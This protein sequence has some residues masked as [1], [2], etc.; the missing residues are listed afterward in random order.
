MT[1][2]QQHC[3]PLG[4]WVHYF[5]NP[6][7]AG[8]D[9]LYSVAVLLLHWTVWICRLSRAKAVWSSMLKVDHFHFQMIQL[10]D[11]FPCRSIWSRWVIPK[12]KNCVLVVMCSSTAWEHICLLFFGTPVNNFYFDSYICSLFHARVCVFTTQSAYRKVA[13]MISQ[14]VSPS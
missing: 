4:H 1:V 7:R 9:F 8:Q 12:W 5:T 11:S 14:L 10:T 6:N 2:K 13:Y 3:L